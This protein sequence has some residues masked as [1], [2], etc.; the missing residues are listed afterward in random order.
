[1]Q[2]RAGLENDD[3]ERE[4][5]YLGLSAEEILRATCLAIANGVYRNKRMIL[6]HEMGTGQWCMIRGL[7]DHG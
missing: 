2:V 5:K 1:M 3:V 4:L 7:R 6:V